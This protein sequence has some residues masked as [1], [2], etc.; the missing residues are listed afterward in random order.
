MSVLSG[1]GP[2]SCRHVKDPPDCGGRGAPEC[3][4]NGTLD[5]ACSTDR[6]PKPARR[7]H[8]DQGRPSNNRLN[9]PGGH[10][11]R[12]ARLVA[13]MD[14]ERV[15]LRQLDCDRPGQT[16]VQSASDTDAG[17]FVQLSFG[18]VFQFSGLA[19]KIGLLGIAL[20]TDRDVLACRH[21]HCARHQPGQTSYRISGRPDPAAATPTTRLAVETSPSFTPSTAAHSQPMRWAMWVPEWDRRLI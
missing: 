20:R 12:N 1:F 17:Q 3:H 10:R 7:H 18:R 6:C 11:L 9:R 15:F 2:R 19:R 5:D 21:R 14:P 13:C 16:L 8:A 4:A